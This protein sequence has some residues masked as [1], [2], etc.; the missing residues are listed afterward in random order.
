MWQKDRKLGE[1]EKKGIHG[2]TQGLGDQ[3]F[4][5]GVILTD[6]QKQQFKDGEITFGFPDSNCNSP[7]GLYIQ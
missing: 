4:R 5:V 3:Q 7:S 1:K 6:V 2:G